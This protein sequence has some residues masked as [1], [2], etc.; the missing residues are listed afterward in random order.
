MLRPFPARDEAVVFLALDHEG[1]L[2][3]RELGEGNLGR[4]A[5]LFGE[6]EEILLRLTIDLAFPGLDRA[7][8]D[9][10]RVVGDGE[11]VVDVDDAAEAPALR[12]GAE[13][14]VE[15]EHPR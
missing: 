15:G 12:A 9:G 2:F 7:V 14:G 5:A 13:R 1:L 3:R 10:E 4:D 6:K 11:A 8:L